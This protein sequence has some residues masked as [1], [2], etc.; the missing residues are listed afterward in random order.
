MNE[1]SARGNTTKPADP[2]LTLYQ[3]VLFGQASLFG[4]VEDQDQAAAVCAACTDRDRWAQ[5]CDCGHLA[6]L[7]AAGES[8]RIGCVMRACDCQGWHPTA[9]AA[10]RA[11][12][13]GHKLGLH[14]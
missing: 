1:T 5:V 10:E 7:H 9:A 12:R 14:K 3:G 6:N 13:L 4:D 2:A 8:G 11:A